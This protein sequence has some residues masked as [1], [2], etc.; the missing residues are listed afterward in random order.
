MDEAEIERQTKMQSEFI[1]LAKQDPLPDEDQFSEQALAAIDQYLTDKEK[2][3][4]AGKTM[5]QAAF[6]QLVSPWF[7]FFMSHE[8][9]ED[10]Q[11]VTCPVLAINGEKD[12]QVDPKLN[13]PAIRTALEAAPTED[14]QLVELPGLNHL[15]QT[16]ATGLVQEYAEIEE[17]FNPAALDVMTNWIREKTQ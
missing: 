3:E 15:F 17:T 1:R 5:V 4:D 6:A 7:Q 8:P 12:L 14:F 13:L 11:K 2:A 9:A 16:S 10:L